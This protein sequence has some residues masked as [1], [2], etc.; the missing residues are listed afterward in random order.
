MLHFHL[1]PSRS[2]YEA[3]RMPAGVPC[4]PSSC[5]GTYVCVFLCKDV[6]AS[7]KPWRQRGKPAHWHV[8]LSACLPEMSPVQQNPKFTGM[9]F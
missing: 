2:G 5:V 8:Q 4:G 7:A 9:N 1:F 6:D 3:G